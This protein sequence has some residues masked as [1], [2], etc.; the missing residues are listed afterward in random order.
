MSVKIQVLLLKYFG[1]YF[2][3]QTEN[4]NSQFLANGDRVI[5][6]QKSNAFHKYESFKVAHLIPSTRLRYFLSR[7]LILVKKMQACSAVVQSYFIGSFFKVIMRQMN[8]KFCIERN[9]YL[10]PV[11]DQAELVSQHP[12]NPSIQLYFRLFQDK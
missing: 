4:L 2:Q 11:F 1:E 9:I 7:Y 3:K 8:K 10:G 5:F 6:L 12:A